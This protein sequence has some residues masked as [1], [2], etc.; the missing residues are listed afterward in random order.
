MKVK[1]KT[2]PKLPKYANKII[3]WN[4]KKKRGVAFILIGY[5]D[6]TLSYF[7]SMY[8]EAQKGYPNLQFADCECGKISKSSCYFGFTLLCFR[9]RK[10]AKGWEIYSGEIDFCW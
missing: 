7:L 6:A 2:L 4:K 5:C 9:V 3:Y 8:L 1:K 10:K